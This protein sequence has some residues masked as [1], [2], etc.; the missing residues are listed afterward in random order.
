MRLVIIIEI[1]KRK[2]KDLKNVHLINLK[3]GLLSNHREKEN[4]REMMTAIARH[5]TVLTMIHMIKKSKPMVEVMINMITR[6][7]TMME[8]LQRSKNQMTIPRISIMEDQIIIKKLKRSLLITYLVKMNRR[9]M[10]M[11]LMTICRMTEKIGDLRDKTRKMK[12]FIKRDQMLANRKWD[13]VEPIVEMVI[14][15][16]LTN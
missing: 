7:L 9:K 13:K 6:S 1:Q 8:L 12:S 5:L 16:L 11:I 2:W 14:S 15:I 3:M 4:W 10:N